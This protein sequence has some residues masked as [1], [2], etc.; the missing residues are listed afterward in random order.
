MSTVPGDPG[1]LS[2]CAATTASVGRRL[3]VLA[4]ALGPEVEALGEGWPG[5]ASVTTRRRGAALAGAGTSTAD[6]LTRVAG[7]LQD[8][9]SDLADLLARARTVEERATAGGLEM[10]DER[11]VPAYGVRGEADAAAQRAQD[12][13]AAR[14]QAEL[15]LVLAQHRRR[16]DFVLGVLRE[17]TERLAALSHGLRHG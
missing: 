11:V 1:S 10:R 15:D 3:G 6:E 9:A 7:V 14:L 2:A 13:L 12:E 17:S 5:R 16:R 4:E 8:Q